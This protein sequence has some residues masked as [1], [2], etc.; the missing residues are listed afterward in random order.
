MATGI[1][2]HEQEPA[3]MKQSPRIIL[4]TAKPSARNRQAARL[5]GW[6][7]Q[8]LMRMSTTRTNGRAGLVAD[9]AVGGI[10]VYEGL[11]RRDVL[12]PAT[13]LTLLAGL[14]LFSFIEYGSH[15]WLFHGSVSIAEQGH[16]KHHEQP[17][18]HDALPFFLSPLLILALAGLLTMLVPLTYALLLSGAVGCG[19][20]A[21]GL[22][23]LLIH[24]RRFRHPL[25][26]RWSSSHHVHHCHPDTNF[27]VTTP[28]WDILLGTQ[29]V[30]KKRTTAS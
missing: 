19:Y 27:G 9:I 20:A 26:R 30:S 21:Y 15:R 11:R 17:L 28:L 1:A 6:I 29:Y 4:L 13:S 8:S 16:R 5:F 3:V 7:T 18:G 14:A 24:Q 22:S 2:N 25:A 12:L 23:H 10:L